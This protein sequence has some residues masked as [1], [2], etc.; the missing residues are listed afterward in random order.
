MRTVMI[1]KDP[2]AGYHETELWSGWMAMLKFCV[3][4][5]VIKDSGT[6]HI[7]NKLNS[8]SLRV[9]T[10]KGNDINEPNRFVQLKPAFNLH[11]EQDI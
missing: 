2:Y 6:S 3:Y 8:D 11:D 4:E 7:L 9:N 1:K 5:L 10:T